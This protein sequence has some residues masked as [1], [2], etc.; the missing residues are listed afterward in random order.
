[1]LS[2]LKTWGTTQMSTD[3]KQTTAFSHER[4][5]SHMAPGMNCYTQAITD[6][7]VHNLERRNQH[8]EDSGLPG[9]SVV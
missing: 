4:S 9:G 6:S 1:M 8:E 7:Q 5:V 3:S 2:Q